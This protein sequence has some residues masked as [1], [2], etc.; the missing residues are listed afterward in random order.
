MSMNINR[1]KPEN[2]SSRPQK[3]ELHSLTELRRSA[4][5]GFQQRVAAAVSELEKSDENRRQKHSHWLSPVPR[6]AALAVIIV[7][8]LST[9]IYL[10]LDIPSIHENETPSVV[11]FML[12]APKAEK[13]DLVGDFTA[14][15]PGQVHFDG[16]DE[17]GNWHASIALPEG[18]YEY[19]FLV[20]GRNWV[21]DFSAP[22]HRPDGFGNMNAIINL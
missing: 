3:D 13:V 2:I 19:L 10:Q 22:A 8:L 20:D 5:P 17:N 21:T 7:F 6:L 12:N 4:P 14:W 9:V 16:P 1:R 18:R 15:Q 11:E